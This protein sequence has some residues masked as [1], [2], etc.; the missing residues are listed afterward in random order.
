MTQKETI[1][2]VDDTNEIRLFLKMILE[3]DYIVS[4]VNSG[5][6][7]LSHIEKELP[8]LLL[9]DVNMPGMNGYQVCEQLR[10]NPQTK[11]LPIIFV[12][13]LD[14][15]EERLAGFEAGGDEYV[16]KP[17]D[18]TDLFNKI[19]ST[20]QRSQESK[21]A[22]EEAAGAMQIAMEAMTVNSELGQIV[23]FVKTGQKLNTTVEIGNAMLSI[24]QEFQLNSCIMVKINKKTEFFGCDEDSMEAQFLVKASN[25]EKRIFSSGIRTIIRDNSIVLLIKNMPLD[26]ENLYGRLKDHLA[27]LMDIAQGYLN[28]VL[29]QENIKH[30][31]KELLVKI[32]D[33]TEDQ[34]K[35]VSSKIHDHNIKSMH[36]IQGM[37]TELEQMLFGLGLDD[38]QEDQLMK[39][40]SKTTLELEKSSKTTKSL[41]DELGVILECL[42]EFLKSES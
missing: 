22:K 33:V 16:I 17:I 32:I 25:S 28:R 10:K 18:P 7:C 2:I 24:T 3:D 14:S 13:G 36:I 6:S 42:Y 41:E 34:I 26:N 29:L 21:T 30:Q 20:L 12:S 1:L 40:A 15:V 27:V 5:K 38:D 37:V 9:L 11:N 31:R 23:E 39:L 35:H 8:D 19:S 4:E